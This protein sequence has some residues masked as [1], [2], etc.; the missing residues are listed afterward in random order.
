MIT[1]KRF[2]LKYTFSVITDADK[3]VLAFLWE[4]AHLQLV[5]LS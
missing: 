2:L 3:K 4:K 5:C 1:D